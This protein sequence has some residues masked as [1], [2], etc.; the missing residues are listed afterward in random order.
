MQPTR[1][2]RLV[3]HLG[4]LPG[5]STQVSH[6]ELH[7]STA[8]LEV[9]H[10][11]TIAFLSCAWQKI[12]SSPLAMRF[13]RADVYAQPLFGRGRVDSDSVEEE[14]ENLLTVSPF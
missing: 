1:L 14:S 9:G 6:E 13:Q 10:Q 5:G 2:A 7:A 3:A 4:L 11:Y 12:R 8:S